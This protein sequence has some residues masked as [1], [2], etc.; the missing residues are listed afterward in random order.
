MLGPLPEVP[1]MRCLLSPD[2]AVSRH[3]GTIPL[4]DS[5]AQWG[6]FSYVTVT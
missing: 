1:W 3:A 2:V 6:N 4:W 5:L